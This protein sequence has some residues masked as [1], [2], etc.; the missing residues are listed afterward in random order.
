MQNGRN[1]YVLLSQVGKVL[2][3]NVGKKF[4][5]KVLT[6]IK[7][8]F[9]DDFDLDDSENGQEK[10]RLIKN[11]AECDAF[12]RKSN[13]LGLINHVGLVFLYAGRSPA[14]RKG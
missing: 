4:H 1:E 7:A 6:T 2:C 11:S 5:G 8:A 3:S 14:Y 12:R 10:I 13:V 9:L